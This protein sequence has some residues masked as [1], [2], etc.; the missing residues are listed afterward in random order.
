MIAT[1]LV[2]G[3]TAALRAVPVVAVTLG[4]LIAV[5]VYLGEHDLVP[6]LFPEVASMSAFVLA[7]VVGVAFIVL[8]SAP[9]N[10]VAASGLTGGGVGYA[11]YRL[12]FGV[13][14]PV[15]AYRL[16]SERRDDEP[17]PDDELP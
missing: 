8:L 11:L 17:G 4:V 1:G 7:L 13:L 2:S 15:P 5:S 12:G 10:V 3:G 9:L 14:R 16:E 6:G